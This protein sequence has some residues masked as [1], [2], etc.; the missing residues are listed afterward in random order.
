MIKANKF[1]P[2]G[3][4]DGMKE[5]YERMSDENITLKTLYQKE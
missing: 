2:F 5:A 4:T 3:I 1:K